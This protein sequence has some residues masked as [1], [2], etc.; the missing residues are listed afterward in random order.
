[1]HFRKALVMKMIE[2]A[3][4]NNEIKI[5]ILDTVMMIST[6]WD[7]VPL[8]TIVNCFRHTGFLSSVTIQEEDHFEDEDNIPLA[9]L[10]REAYVVNTDSNVTFDDFVDVDK[11]L[12]T[13]GEL[14]DEDLVM[15]LKGLQ[16]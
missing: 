9:Q 8:N 14:T 4:E 12:A 16:T 3:G 11:D 13:W 1:M 7:A 15:N 6:A 2:N 5:N 10:I